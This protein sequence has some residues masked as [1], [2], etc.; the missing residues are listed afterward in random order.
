MVE[1]DAVAEEDVLALAGLAEEEGGA[2]AD[3]IDAVVNEGADGVGQ[4]ELAGL[5]VDDREEDHAEAVLHG[6]VFVELVEDDFRLGAP[7][8]L[9]GDAHAFAVGEVLDVG[10]VLDDLVGDELGDTLD[11]VGLVDLV[12]DL[13]DDDALLAVAALFDGDLGADHE[14]AAAGAVGVG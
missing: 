11:E 10:D 8:E 1:G 3:D 12:G 2:A 5:A 7:L 13:G 6:G 14:A 4:G 9:D